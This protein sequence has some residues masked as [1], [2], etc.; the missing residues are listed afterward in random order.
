[1]I[2]L[3]VDLPSPVCFILVDNEVLGDPCIVPFCE[4]GFYPLYVKESSSKDQLIIRL[5]LIEGH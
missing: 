2:P 3:G 4:S 5:S 1:M